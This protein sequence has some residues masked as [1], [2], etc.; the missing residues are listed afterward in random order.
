MAG[1]GRLSPMSRVAFRP[2]HRAR[3]PHRAVGG[4][5]HQTTARLH[6]CISWR[7]GM[8]VATFPAHNYHLLKVDWSLAI[9]PVSLAKSKISISQAAVIFFC[10][11][12]NVKVLKDTGRTMG[13]AHPKPGNRDRFSRHHR[14][15]T[16]VQCELFC[17]RIDMLFGSFL[18][19]LFSK[20]CRNQMTLILK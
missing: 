8:S 4:G 6:V 3:Y 11:I 7:P 15:R 10:R 1:I 16:F 19:A 17:C 14:S 20:L 13:A 9:C 18:T 12:R 2:L 5:I